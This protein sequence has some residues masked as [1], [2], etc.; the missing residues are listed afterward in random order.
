M[1]RLTVG[2]THLNKHRLVDIVL[3]I[4]NSRCHMNDIFNFGSVAGSASGLF[5]LQDRLVGTVCLRAFIIL[6]RPL[7]SNFRWKRTRTFL[8]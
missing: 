1:N 7:V 6:L 4:S 5:P 3:P 2:Y 8:I